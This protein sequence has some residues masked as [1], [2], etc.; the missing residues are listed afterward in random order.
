MKKKMNAK[1]FS[2]NNEYGKIDFYI[3]VDREFFTF[4]LQTTSL[5]TSTS[6]T[7]SV[8]V[9]KMHTIRHS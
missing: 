4:L 2:R 9:W 6:N 1:V 5:R 7:V 3:E 8:N